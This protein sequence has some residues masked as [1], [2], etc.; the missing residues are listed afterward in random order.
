MGRTVESMSKE[1]YSSEQIHKY[2]FSLL[3]EVKQHCRDTVLEVVQGSYVGL[4]HY[5]AVVSEKHSFLQDN[6]IHCQ[7]HLHNNLT[8]VDFPLLNCLLISQ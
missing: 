1:L 6:M 8:I 4:C 5:L 3:K 2:N 7:T